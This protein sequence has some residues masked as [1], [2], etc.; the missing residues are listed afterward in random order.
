MTS[1]KSHILVVGGAGYI[2]AVTVDYLMR[3]GYRVTV[4]DD[5][6][7]GH[8][9]AVPAEAAFYQGDYADYDMVAGLVAAARDSQEPISCAIHLAAR[10]LVGESVAR[11]DIYWD[12]NVGGGIRLVR[13]LVDQGIRRL[14]FSSTAAIFGNPPELPITEQT[15]KLPNNPY[16]RTKLAFEQYLD[17]MDKAVGLKAICLRYFNAAGASGRLGEDHS[18]ETHLIPLALAAAAGKRP[19]L[20]VFGNDYPT[21][22]GTCVR[23]YIHVEDLA[24]AHEKAVLQL[25]EPTPESVS[26]NLGNGSGFSVLEVIQTAEKVTGKRVPYAFSDRRPG[27][28]PA[29]VASSQAARDKLGWTPEKPSL[30]TIVADA[31]RWMQEHPNGYS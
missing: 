8:R 28:P 14:V 19:P 20:E 26:F 21:P 5:L 9:L 10:S 30:E 7:R 1:Q 29:L 31:W 6:S 18:P 12:Q 27:D 15:P 2:G 22:D 16:G 17:D 4:L 25:L 11:P 23:D 24:Q 13:A 3:N